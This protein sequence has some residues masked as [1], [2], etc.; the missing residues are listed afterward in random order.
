[1][2]L[3]FCSILL[4][5]R[6]FAQQTQGPLTNQGVGGLVVA[7]VP[8]SEV[9]RVIS[10]APRVDFDL[11]PAST[12]ALLKVGV[13]EEVIKAMGARE[14]GIV[15]NIA[16]ARSKLASGAPT[17]SMASK[18]RVF[19]AQANDSWSFTAGRHFGQG[20][21][22]PQTVEVMKTFGESCPNVIITSNSD[23]A[24][25]QVLFERE[26]N[27]AVRKHNKFAAFN[28][29]GDM[30]YSASTRNLGNSVRGFCSSIQ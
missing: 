6:A 25:Y 9:I 8:E 15:A 29:N 11:R 12:D 17:V 13:S 4:L 26:S 2:K 7:G 22:H 19:V 20:S 27:K 5:A 1:M 14:G 3:L 23:N 24:D 10:N 18:P 21:T 16:P 30:V 28:R